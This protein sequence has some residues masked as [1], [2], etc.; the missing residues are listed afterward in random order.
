MLFVCN[1]KVGGEE[2]A[3]AVV[4]VCKHKGGLMDLMGSGII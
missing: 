4:I 2:T 1:E 3:S